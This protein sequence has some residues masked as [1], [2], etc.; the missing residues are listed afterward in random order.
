M[1]D[2]AGWCDRCG[3]TGRKPFA[4][5]VTP[6]PFSRGKQPNLGK[7]LNVRNY[8]TADPPSYRLIDDVAF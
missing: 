8:E 7:L 6:I 2:A 1:T 5:I 3:Y 4:Q